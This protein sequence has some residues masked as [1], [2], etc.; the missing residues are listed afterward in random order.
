VLSYPSGMSVSNRALI[1]L[2]DLLRERRAILGTRWRRL[3]PGRQALLT[4]A[5]KRSASRPRHGRHVRS[6][7]SAP[8]IAVVSVRRM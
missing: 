3:A 5:C 1:M 8:V 6:T 2:A 4:L 7:R